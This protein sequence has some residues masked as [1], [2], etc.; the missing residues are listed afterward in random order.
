MVA[1]VT[2]VLLGLVSAPVWAGREPTLNISPSLTPV[3]VPPLIKPLPNALASL[4]LS[5]MPSIPFTGWPP[6]TG[7]ALHR[8]SVKVVSKHN[9]AF[10][11]RQQSPSPVMKKPQWQYYHIEFDCNEVRP[12]AMDVYRVRLD[13]RIM[14]HKTIATPEQMGLYFIEGGIDPWS[15]QVF[16]WGK[17]QCALKLP[18][19]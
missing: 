19:I 14:A 8:D 2:L 6:T 5:K 10:W 13:N 4:D 15:T 11:V 3:P 18:A 1:V 7:V 9:V 12:I 17:D 16:H